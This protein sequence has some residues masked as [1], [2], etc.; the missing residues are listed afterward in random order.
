VR[1]VGRERLEAALAEG[2]GALV[3]A[4][5]LGN[6]E[7]LVRLGALL[8]RPAA[9]VTRRFRWA[10]ADRA[11]R[12]LRRGGPALLP[13]GGS[14]REVLATLRANG[15]VAYVLDQHAPGR[16]AVRVP[17]FGR[18]ASTSPDLVRLAR[19][20][21]APV[22]PVFIFR[23]DA[24][25]VVEIG[26]PVPLP[27]TANARDDVAR[28]TAECT[29]RIEEAVRRAPEQW[30]WI[31]RRWKSGHRPVGCRPREAAVSSAERR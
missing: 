12:A 20:S 21:R 17:F 13:A 11:W 15:V 30:L 10:P 25:H 2:R 3:L 8:G 4:A 16:R 9:V 6:F 24:C 27:R 1:I 18:A 14:A 5:H 28:G 29:A 22:V 26:A 31:H 23:R 7:L 19:L